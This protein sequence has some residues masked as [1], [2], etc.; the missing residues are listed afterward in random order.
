[1]DIKDVLVQ[2]AVAD[3][4]ADAPIVGSWNAQSLSETPLEPEQPQQADAQQEALADLNTDREDWHWRPQDQEPDSYVAQEAARRSQ[5]QERPQ[6]QQQ[7]QEA[8]PPTPEA[9]QDS[10]AQLDTFVR[11]QNLNDPASAHQFAEEFC[12]AFG[13]DMYKSGVNVEGLGNVMAKTAVSALNAYQW[14]NGDISRLGP[15]PAESARAFTSEFLRAWGVDPRAVQVNERQLAET[16]FLGAVNFLGTY[17]QFG[18]KVS[19]LDQLNNP[20]A[21][22]WFLGSFLQAVGVQNAAVDRTVALKLA[23]AGGKYLLSF[24]NKVGQLQPRQQAS[25][26]QS[27]QRAS[28]RGFRT[29]QDIFSP[30]VLER[31]DLEKTPQRKGQDFTPKARRVTSPFQSNQDI[32]NSESLADF[33]RL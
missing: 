13:S 30:D 10:I 12:G 21:A 22:E 4:L 19:N 20:E 9:V 17:Q 11:E 14:C 5:A 8:P 2:D 1:V 16:V 6:Q 33:Q 32:F 28:R 7:Q 25:R 24:M 3:S 15:I 18:G 27:G 26:R 31:L 29:N 23:D